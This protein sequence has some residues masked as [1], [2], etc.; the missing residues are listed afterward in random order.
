MGR[1]SIILTYAHIIRYSED[2]SA[3]LP[4]GLRSSGMIGSAKTL[5]LFAPPDS[6]MKISESD[7]KQ[8]K[9]VFY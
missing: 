3:F 8:I 4:R 9:V 7:F 2:K 1:E 6:K 5:E